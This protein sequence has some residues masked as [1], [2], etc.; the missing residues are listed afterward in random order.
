MSDNS[1]L[2]LFQEITPYDQPVKLDE[3]LSE[4]S[5]VIRKFVVLGSYSHVALPLWI[6][7]TYCINSVDTAPILAISSPEKRCG[8]TT[9]LSIL[10]KLVYRPLPTASITASPLYRLIELH[11]PTILIDEADT[12]I[13]GTE[14]LAGIIN[15]GH[16]RTAARVIRSV[17]DNHEPKAFSTW[18]PKAIALILLLSLSGTL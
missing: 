17:G 3:L 1:K 18:C 7:F 10:D 12:F 14:G 13:R 15:S 2:S 6:A 11:Q 9:L 8:K 16:T 5:G 4:L